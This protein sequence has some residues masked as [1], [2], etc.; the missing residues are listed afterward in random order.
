MAR[1]LV[2]TSLAL[3]NVSG[4]VLSSI[5]PLSIIVSQKLDSASDEEWIVCGISESSTASASG[6]LGGAFGYQV[7]RIG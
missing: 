5:D 3:S 4:T 2:S 6:I 1:A 7:S